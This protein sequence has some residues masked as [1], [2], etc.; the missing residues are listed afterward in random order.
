MIITKSMLEEKKEKYLKDVKD[1]AIFVHPTDTI[2][3]LGCNA[4]NDKSVLKLRKLKTITTVPFSIIAPSKKWI[5]DNCEISQEA[6]KWLNKI[7]GP[8]TLILKL[9]N[10]KAVSKH[11]NPKGDT[12]GVRIPKHWIS[13]YVKEL[14]LPIIS[15]SANIAGEEYIHDIEEFNPKIS[16]NVDFIIYDNFEEGKPSDIVHLTKKIPKIIKRSK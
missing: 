15:T 16:N 14:G 3:G 2:F 11:V 4:L 8:F 12:I 9:K 6:K 5:E 7:P 13:N 10:K 1:G